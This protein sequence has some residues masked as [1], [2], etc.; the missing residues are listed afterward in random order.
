MCSLAV[1]CVLVIIHICHIRVTTTC[2]PTT[3]LQ[4]GIK[5]EGIE[6]SVAV[7]IHEPP[8]VCGD[9]TYSMYDM[10]G[11]Q[12]SEGEANGEGGRRSGIW[13]TCHFLPGQARLQIE[14]AEYQIELVL[15]W[16]L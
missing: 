11:R 9:V 8:H 3:D 13:S 7:C 2:R 6:V 10:R 12:E 16:R 15:L 5:F 4:H 1:E 14:G